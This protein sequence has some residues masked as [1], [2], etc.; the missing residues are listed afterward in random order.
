MPTP[1]S[2]RVADDPAIFATPAPPSTIQSVRSS[3]VLSTPVQPSPSPG[4]P[5]FQSHT[6]SNVIPFVIPAPKFTSTVS[7]PP[8]PPAPI[9]T[10]IGPRVV[11]SV[12]VP[13]PSVPAVAVVHVAHTETSQSISPPIVVT[14]E[15][16][17]SSSTTATHPPPVE[18]PEVSQGVSAH[19]EPVP[20]AVAAPEGPDH[21]IPSETDTNDVGAKR[22][23]RKRSRPVSDD[24]K[25][26]PSKKR[27][28][29]FVAEDSAEER[30]S[31]PPVKR[32]SRAKAKAKVTP[33][34][35]KPAKGKSKGKARASQ[36]PA[37]EGEEPLFLASGSEQ[38]DLENEEKEAE[39][40]PLMLTMASLCDDSAAGK[41]S[42]KGEEIQANFVQWKSRNRDR[43]AQMRTA[44]ERRKRGLAD[45]NEEEIPPQAKEGAD[46]EGSKQAEDGVQ[47]VGNQ[48][49]EQPGASIS[50]KEDDNMNGDLD[51]A[52]NLAQNRYNVQVRIGPNG[53]TIIDEESMFVDRTEPE[54]AGNYTHIVESDATKFTNSSSY[55][56]K[57]RGSRWS[58]EETEL[59]YNVC[60]HY[61]LIRLDLNISLQALSQYGQNFEL[62]ACVMPG[63]DRKACKN[64]FK[65]EDKRNSARITHCLKNGIPI[66]SS[67]VLVC[68][69]FIRAD[70]DLDMSTLSRMTGRDFS[71]P[72]PE[73]K[74]PERATIP[75]DALAS[76]PE[77]DNGLTSTSKRGRKRSR[78]STA[79]L[80]D[81]VQIIGS[82][83]TFAD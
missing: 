82:A 21:F 16:P 24:P 20:D 62:I 61:Y 25:D 40:D 4:P 10:P 57:L 35:A 32:K 65:A 76:E 42:T 38:D 2:T 19:P 56:K 44:M 54:D 3:S 30:S 36:T 6:P 78:S 70:R 72:V 8:R 18:P 13:V 14:N 79:N 74:I 15:T 66:G 7:V 33:K 47:I 11:Q 27:K 9:A 81:G 63:R 28:K 39:V 55:S 68:V 45:E 58:G 29:V 64:K 67:S 37:A 53:E 71:G 80:G 23:T 31:A 43:R 41:P 26:T 1:E 46:A 34:P 73:I 48:D 75:P 22:L 69:S 5:A 52:H 59:F 83:E 60:F 51:F 49:G 50:D 77:S 17:Q 12:S